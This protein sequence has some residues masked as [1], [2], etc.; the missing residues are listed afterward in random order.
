MLNLFRWEKFTSSGLINIKSKKRID[1]PK[2]KN[3]KKGKKSKLEAVEVEDSMSFRSMFLDQEAKSTGKS[4]RVRAAIEEELSAEPKNRQ[5]LA[6]NQIPFKKKFSLI[7]NDSSKNEKIPLATN[8][9]RSLRGSM[10]G[11]KSQN[12]QNSE[13]GTLDQNMVSLADDVEK[14]TSQAINCPFFAYVYFYKGKFLKIM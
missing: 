13:E 10:F 7:V 8:R 2:D 3:K 5:N 14:G 6:P 4:F 12:S 11:S 1:R 9:T